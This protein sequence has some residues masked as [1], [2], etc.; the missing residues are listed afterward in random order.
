MDGVPC[1]PEIRFSFTDLSTDKP[2]LVEPW[3][4][5]FGVTGT[6]GIEV[7][8]DIIYSEP[9]FCLVE[10]AISSQLWSRAF[11]LGP[12]DFLY[13]SMEAEET[14]LVWIRSQPGGLRVGSV[15]EQHPCQQLFSFGEIVAALDDY[16]GQLR[17]A[18]KGKFDIDIALLFEWRAKQLR[19]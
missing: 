11:V 19:A 1:K 4:I 18:V 8:R 5:Y 12:E 2:R 10:F 3:E 7:S 14:G 15:F 16:Y 13:T 17:H 6:F 9:H